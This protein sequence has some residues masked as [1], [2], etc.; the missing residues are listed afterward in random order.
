MNTLKIPFA[1][2]PLAGNEMRYVREVL[3]SGW[4]TTAE[5]AHLFEERF[6]AAVLARYACAVTSCTAAL[7]LGVEALGVNRRDKVMVQSMTFAASAEIIRYLGATPVFLDTEYG[8]NLLTTDI[9]GDAIRKHPD[10]RTVII[11]HY[12]GQPA[13]MVSANGNGILDVCIKNNI[14]IVEDAAHAFPSRLNGRP[15]GSFGDVTCFSFYANKTITTGEGGM[16]VTN[17]EQICRRARTMRLH[18]IDRDIWKRYTSGNPSWEYDVVSAGFKYNMSDVNA[19]IG[20]A[21][22]EKAEIFRKERQRVAE[23]YYRQLSG[24]EMI[25]LP[26][27]RVPHDDHAWHLFPLVLNPKARISRNEF[28]HKMSEAGIGT[29]VHYKPLH[30]M[31]YYQKKYGLKPEDFPNAERTWR[32]NVSLPVYPYMTE[33][34]LDYV[35]GTIRKLLTV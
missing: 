8:T 15:V 13:E 22:L 4:L 21:Q 24:L 25:D 23:Y 34:E 17:D 1:R 16:L 9:L 3:E 2:V 28:I 30:R 11:V 26:V 27:C 7:H 6:A 14:R 31:T 35:T 29:S 33:E 18:G 12:G 10:V 32:G 20:L 5:K 19:A